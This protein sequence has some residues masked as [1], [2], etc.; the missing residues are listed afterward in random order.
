MQTTT[1]LEDVRGAASLCIKCANCT[2][3][4]WP[5]NY[6]LC[7]IFYRDRCYTYSAGGLLYLVQALLQNKIDFNQSVAD[8]AFTCTGCLAIISS[9]RSAS[10]NPRTA[11]FEALYAVC[12]GIPIRPNRLEMFTRCPSPLAIRCGRNSFEPCTTPQKLMLMI[13]SSSS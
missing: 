7:P 12:P 5:L 9:M 10:L 11:N 3:G 6:P 2:Y 8:L 4:A 13:H 1:T